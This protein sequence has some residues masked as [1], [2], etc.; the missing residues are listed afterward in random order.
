MFEPEMVIIGCLEFSSYKETAFFPI[1]DIISGF[2][3]SL[4]CVF[5]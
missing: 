3:S 4:V 2:L 1:I 5:M